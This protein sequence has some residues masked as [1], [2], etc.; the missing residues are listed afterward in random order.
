[1]SAYRLSYELNIGSVILMVDDVDSYQMW[2]SHLLIPYTHYVPVKS[3]LSDLFSQVLWCRDNEE[4]MVNIIKECKKFYNAYLTKG[5]IYTYMASTL[6]SLKKHIGTYTYNPYYKKQLLHEQQSLDSLVFANRAVPHDGYIFYINS[7]GSGYHRF[8]NKYRAIQNTNILGEMAFVKTLEKTKNTVIDIFSVKN[9]QFVVKK[10]SNSDE[11][12][13]EQFI[14]QFCINDLLKTIPNF[15]Y[16]FGKCHLGLVVEK[17]EGINFMKWLDTQFNYTQYIHILSQIHLAIIVAQR[18]CLFVHYDLFP[19]NIMI[20]TLDTEVEIEYPIDVGKIVS[21]RTNL[22]PIIIDY[23]KSSGTSRGNG[24]SL[25][26]HS[27]VKPFEFSQDHDM[28]TII[29]SSIKHIIFNRHYM[30]DKEVINGFISL[31]SVYYNNI[32][33]YADV[34]RVCSEFSFSNSLSEAVIIYKKNNCLFNFTPKTRITKIFNVGVVNNYFNYFYDG[35]IDNTTK[36]YRFSDEILELY[37]SVFNTTNILI[38]SKISKDLFCTEL[39][40]YNIIENKFLNI[41]YF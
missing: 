6:S 17:I 29:V 8:Y 16:T 12:I 33:N 27:V 19:W 15:L 20:Q 14:G 25:I 10:T 34:R 38:K 9:L 1:M 24:T 35:F 5:G 23:G 7:N 28:K 3:D 39:F 11:M 31:L 4:K 36:V 26:I 13:H 22:I 2:F 30:P 21:V 40:I 37:F 18:K 41:F 32:A